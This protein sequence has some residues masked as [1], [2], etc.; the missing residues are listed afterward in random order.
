MSSSVP[1]EEEVRRF[2]QQSYYMVPIHSD[3]ETVYQMDWV[4]PALPVVREPDDTD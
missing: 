2:F 1:T 4:G 3:G